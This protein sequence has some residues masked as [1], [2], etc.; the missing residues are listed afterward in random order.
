MS[1]ELVETFE[2]RPGRL[3]DSAVRELT[4]VR[5]LLPVL[6][7][8]L[9]AG[10]HGTIACSDAAPEGLGVARRRMDPAAVASC[11]RFSE[12]WR[13]RVAGAAAARESSLAC[14][15]AS[16]R[17]AAHSNGYRTTCASSGSAEP[18]SEGLE[19]VLDFPVA[20]GPFLGL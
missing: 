4:L 12:R 19:P 14:G 6:Q 17:L 13:F 2:G 7:T 10:W 11:A 18:N 5:D 8:D 20:P 15:S 9:T 16:E 3:W 1:T